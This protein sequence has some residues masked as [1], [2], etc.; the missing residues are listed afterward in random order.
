MLIPLRQRLRV[1]EIPDC[2]YW[3]AMNTHTH[4]PIQGGFGAP[5]LLPKRTAPAPPECWRKREPSRH[6]W[7]AGLVFQPRSHWQ[8]W[9]RFGQSG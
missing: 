8:T 9:T 5:C 2:A 3:A 6:P 4:V 7:E 1:I